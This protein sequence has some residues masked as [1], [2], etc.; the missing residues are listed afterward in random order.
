[1]NGVDELEEYHKKLMAVLPD[2]REFAMRVLGVVMTCL[3]R[4]MPSDVRQGCMV[5]WIAKLLEVERR[6]N[7]DENEKRTLQ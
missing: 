1:V 3:F 4:S 5:E 2:D 7:A 6:S